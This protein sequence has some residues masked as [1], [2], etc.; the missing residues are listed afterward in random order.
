MK[1]NTIQ[2][3]I[4]D[5]HALFSNALKNVLPIYGNLNVVGTAKNASNLWALFELNQIDLV[6]LD[7][8]LGEEENGF[9][10]LEQLKARNIKT[11]V[12]V[13][14]MHTQ[15]SY[16][17]KAKNLGANG[18][19][20][21]ESETEE[22]IEAIEAVTKSDIFYCNIQS[23]F[24]NSPFEVL[25]KT[26]LEIV[27][28]LIMGKNNQTIADETYRAKHTV[29]AHR[30]NIYKKMEINGIVDLVKLGV[31]YGLVSEI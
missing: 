13:I 24:V 12:L 18:F 11:K 8:G 17:E 5:D 15:K 1:E 2:I 31:K 30:K 22:L 26:E 6:L 10:I 7:L 28:L 21:K 29:D 14:S 23:A 27:R 4:V 25:T 3:A 9:D 19:M 20:A 16:I